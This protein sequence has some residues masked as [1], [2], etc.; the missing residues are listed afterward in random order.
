MIICKN[1]KVPHVPQKPQIVFL[2]LENGSLG[3]LETFY[4]RGFMSV[5]RVFWEIK[6]IF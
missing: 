6:R 4:P 2:S 3:S 1:R 5:N